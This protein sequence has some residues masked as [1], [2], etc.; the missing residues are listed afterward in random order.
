MKRDKLECLVER[1]YILIII[2]LSLVILLNIAV[3][4]TIQNEINIFLTLIC[5]I[6]AA[7][8]LL[9][10]VVW[11]TDN[12][13]LAAVDSLWRFLAFIKKSD[14][15]REKC[16]VHGIVSFALACV[17]TALN[18]IIALLYLGFD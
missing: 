13:L 6:C 9:K 10:L 14:L 2:I 4:R 15:Y 12:Q 8:S 17:F 11:R 7:N 16:F 3:I 1:F 5:I 18:V